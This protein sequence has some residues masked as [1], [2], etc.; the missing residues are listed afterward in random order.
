MTRLTYQQEFLS[1]ITPK[2]RTNLINAHYQEIALNKG[3]I[4]LDPD[5]D[6]YHSLE[7]AGLFRLFTART[8]LAKGEPY[9]TLVGYFGVFV[10]PHMHYKGHEFATNDVIYI[11]PKYR[12]G[13]AGIRL[14]RFAERCLKEDGV[15][16]LQIN[17]KAHQSFAPVLE[18]M[19]YQLNDLVY[20]KLL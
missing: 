9:D 16:V 14:I 4:E 18:R 15:S 6:R 11:T 1:T 10:M 20:G 17:T 5:W 13:F 3:K 7:Q 8:V 12:K 2:E 19:G